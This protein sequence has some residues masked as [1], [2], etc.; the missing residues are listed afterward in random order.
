MPGEREILQLLRHIRGRLAG[1]VSLDA[2]AVRAGWS[3]SHSPRPSRAETGKPPKQYPLP[4]RLK[5]AAARLLTGREPI[6]TIAAGVGFASHE[7]FTR[8]FR[9]HFNCTPAQYRTRGSRR[10]PPATRL[11]H[12]GVTATAGPCIRL[13]HLPT[14]RPRRLTMAMLSIERRELMAQPTL[15]VQLRAARHELA[16]A[17]GEGVAK[18]Y[19]F[20]QQGGVALAG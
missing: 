10:V 2:L 16:Q 11:R 17:I 6:M 4:P 1:D 9:R 12:A 13:F 3:P 5:Q 18:V 20:A 19:A 14:A 8:A 15:V 7:V